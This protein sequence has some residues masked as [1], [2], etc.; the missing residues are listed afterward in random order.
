MGYTSYLD[1]NVAVFT[2]FEEEPQHVELHGSPQEY[3]EAKLGLFRDLVDPGKQRAVVNM[4]DPASSA[5]LAAI[6]DVPV[7]TYSLS[8]PQADVWAK[9]IDLTVW[10]TEVS[11]VGLDRDAPTAATVEA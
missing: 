6:K 10:E 2:N 1:V 9:K 4:D 7:I 11:A 3:L 5:V 8:N